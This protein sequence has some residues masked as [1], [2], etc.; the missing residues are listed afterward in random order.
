M[1]HEEHL[2]EA[3]GLRPSVEAD[4]V[5]AQQVRDTSA[6]RAAKTLQDRAELTAVL[7]HIHGEP[8]RELSEMLALATYGHAMDHRRVLDVLD[9]LGAR[10]PEA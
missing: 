4:K 2:K 5:V 10:F 6:A 9:L 3:E 7:S 1:S 8:A